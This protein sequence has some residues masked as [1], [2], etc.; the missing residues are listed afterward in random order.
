MVCKLKERN[1]NSLNVHRRAEGGTERERE[2]KTKSKEV[3]RGRPG[4]ILL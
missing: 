4:D 1:Y 2:I 3:W